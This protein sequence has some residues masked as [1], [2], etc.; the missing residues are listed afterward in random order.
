MRAIVV[1]HD[2]RIVGETYGEGFNA[3]TPLLGWSMTK[4]VNA[5]LVGMAIKDGK[6]SLDP[7]GSVSAMGRGRA[8]GYLG[9]RLDGHVQRFGIQ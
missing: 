4:T 5:A 9:G 3:S 2:G 7:E 8:R 6:L 1:V